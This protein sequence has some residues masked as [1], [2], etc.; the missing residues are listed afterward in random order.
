MC[1]SG[2]EVGERYVFFFYLGRVREVLPTKETSEQIPE[3]SEK[4]PWEPLEEESS[5][6]RA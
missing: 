6:Q 4:K 5:R 2:G 1:V 3:S